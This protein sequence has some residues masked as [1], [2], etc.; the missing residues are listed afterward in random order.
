MV[1][2]NSK[3]PTTEKVEEM[4]KKFGIPMTPELMQLGSNEAISNAL[5]ETAASKHSQAA[6]GA[7]CQSYLLWASSLPMGRQ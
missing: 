3:V 1:L 5:V 7:A 2:T 6:K 4:A